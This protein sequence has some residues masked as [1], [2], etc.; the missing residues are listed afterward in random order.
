LLEEL[1]RRAVRHALGEPVPLAV[2]LGAEV[3]TVEELLEAED[4][5]A[6]LRRLA[7]QAEVLLDH[8]VLDLLDRTLRVDVRRHRTL[9][10]TAA[11]RASHCSSKSRRTAGEGR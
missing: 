3:G 9:D 10:Q 11:D 4:L 5:D 6:L 2:L 1:R 7:D 8:G